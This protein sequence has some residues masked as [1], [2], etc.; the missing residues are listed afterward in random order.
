ML[1]E[2]GFLLVLAGTEKV[3]KVKNID[4]YRYLISS[5][6]TESSKTGRYYLKK[7]PIELSMQ[8]TN[9]PYG[10]L[11]INWYQIACDR[12]LEIFAEAGVTIQLIENIRAILDPSGARK[13]CDQGK[14]V[15][16]LRLR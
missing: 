4:L 13:K 3:T 2:K 15:T 8:I 16:M 6:A 11:D 5:T 1:V 7:F 14:K 9:Q 10:F 12:L